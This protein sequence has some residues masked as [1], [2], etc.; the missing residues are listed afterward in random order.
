MTACFSRSVIDGRANGSQGLSIVVSLDRV[1]VRVGRAVRRTVGPGLFQR[2]RRADQ[3]RRFRF[4]F[5]CVVAAARQRAR[6]SVCSAAGWFDDRPDRCRDRAGSAGSQ[7][8]PSG[9]DGPSSTIGSHPGVVR[10][11]P[12]GRRRRDALPQLVRRDSQWLSASSAGAAW[13]RHP[14]RSPRRAART[15]DGIDEMQPPGEA[16]DP[17]S[18]RRAHRVAHR[19]R[20]GRGESLQTGLEHRV[21]DLLDPAVVAKLP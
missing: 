14:H 18:A 3:G 2:L 7:T 5:Q 12:P 19:S 20:A 1:G 6:S 10:R 13:C 15:A 16:L 4:Q 21:G 9:P 17:S 8:V 11:R